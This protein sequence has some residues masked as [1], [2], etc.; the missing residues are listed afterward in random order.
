MSMTSAEL[1]RECHWR[2][3]MGVFGARHEPCERASQRAFCGVS[4]LLFAASAAVG[5]VVLIAGALQFTADRRITLP[6]AENSVPRRSCMLP[7]D[8]A[9]PDLRAMPDQFYPGTTQSAR[10]KPESFML[11]IDFPSGSLFSVQV[12]S[13][14]PLIVDI[15]M[16]HV[17]LGAGLKPHLVMHSRHNRTFRGH[18]HQ[19]VAQT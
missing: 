4:A 9:Q 6:T 19:H 3:W 1:S 11:Q 10:M 13:I 18:C 5:V 17:T 2:N 14:K 16:I 8:M 12:A 15:N 7:V